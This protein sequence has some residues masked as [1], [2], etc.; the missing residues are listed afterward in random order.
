[1]SAVGV[2]PA[3]DGRWLV[4][5]TSS[6]GP[7]VVI[8]V[9]CELAGTG[10]SDSIGQVIVPAQ[11][12]HVAESHRRRDKWSH[13]KY[14]S[15]M[16]G[17]DLHEWLE[18]STSPH[19]RAHVF[20]SNVTNAFTLSRFWSRL[21]ARGCKL[22]GKE[23]GGQRGDLNPFSDR[24][25]VESTFNSATLPTGESIGP[26]RFASIIV[27]GPTEIVRYKC[28]GRSFIWTNF[29]QYIDP[30]EAM[31]ARALNYAQPVAG[32]ERQVQPLGSPDPIG[33]AYLWCSFFRRL[34]D[35]WTKHEGGP[36]GPSVASCAYSYLRRRLLPKTILRHNDE[37]AGTLEEHAIFGGRR[38][39]WFAG[40]VGDESAWE[41][42]A[43]DAPARSD[44]GTLLT[45]ME[46]HDIRSMYPFLLERMPYPV[47]LLGVKRSLTV[48]A[49]ADYLQS[50]G[51]IARVLI[52][53]DV[54]EYP[55]RTKAGIRFP[56]GR[57]WTTLAGPELQTALSAGLVEIVAQ[58][59]V[60]A[61]GQPFKEVAG[62]LLDF[63]EKYREAEE[64]AWEAFSKSLGNSMSGR[65][66]QRSYDWTP[67]PKVAARE[68]WGPFTRRNIDTGEV[69]HYRA[70]CGMVF[71]RTECEVKCRPMGSAYAYLTAY[72]RVL[73][74]WV[75]A[76][77]PER[78][79]LAQDTDGIWTT[80]AASKTLY[81]HADP[82]CRQRGNLHL[83]HPTPAGRFFGAQHYWWGH[84][85]VLSGHAMPRIKPGTTMATI[86]EDHVP[87]FSCRDTPEPYV[88]HREIEREIGRVQAHGGID[89]NGWI[90]PPY[91]WLS[92]DASEPPPDTQ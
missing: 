32:G 64:P 53:P 49:C 25:L 59:A 8:S 26:Y 87:L 31:I 85:W 4:P 5:A 92:Y 38:S 42:F 46:H 81:Q 77:C 40:N 58:A 39:I 88:Y 67:A 48:S 43:A 13:P 83:E 17:E 60:Y 65:M 76:M 35:W 6:Y 11:R 72:G 28:N 29:S 55:L 79:V 33:R 90:S 91:E 75:R 56:M 9:I 22:G 66:A 50:F 52:R 36:W 34:A 19:R 44:A 51:V 21:E 41:P 37:R 54:P 61:M 89:D 1:M 86:I 68:L 14:Q 2:N 84:H 23:M 71:E 57:F 20:T 47:K 74:R 30:D 3:S 69:R 82:L 27:G 45:S 73:M 7:S 78:S 62:E 24:I 80:P 70:L 15:F 10:M 12:W 63:R 18:T 16:N